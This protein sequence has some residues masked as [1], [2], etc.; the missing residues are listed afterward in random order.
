MPPVTSTRDL[1]DERFPEIVEMRR[2]LHARPELSFEEHET[3]GFIRDRLRALGAT[4]LTCPTP[5]GAVFAIDGGTPGR[6]VLLRADIDGLPVE[7]AVDVPF[8][9]RVDGVM[10]A[11]GHDAH[12]AILLGVAGVVAARSHALPGRYVFLFQPA[13]ERLAGARALID[14]GVLETVRADRVIGCHVASLLPAGKVFVRAGVCLADGQALRFALHG[15]GGHGAF[16]GRRGGVVAA[17]IEL[18]R[19]LPSVVDGL[20]HEGVPCVCSAGLVQ[21][22]TACNVLPSTA[23]VEGTLRTFTEEQKHEALGRLRALCA[24]VTGETDVAVDLALTGHA[25]AVVNDGG[26]SEVVHAAA[27]RVLGPDCVLSGPPFP[28]SD[29]VSE[30][31]RRVP[32]CF[33]LAGVARRDGSSGMHHSPAFDLEEEALRAAALVMADGA[34]A[35]AAGER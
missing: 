14:G 22:G 21:A 12:T 20:E 18:V 27:E 17:V 26:A 24:R 33:F 35:L 30:F 23:V 1:V 7:E 13:E 2:T 3:T 6:T 19:S 11:C 25:P 28:P 8:R 32:G 9:S 10:H 5:T 34:V 29:D 16:P 4:E 15:S 31:L